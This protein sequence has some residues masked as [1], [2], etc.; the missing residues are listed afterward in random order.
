[1]PDQ[2]V[3]LQSVKAPTRKF[4]VISFDKETGLMKLRT[5]SGVLFEY[6]NMTKEKAKQFG[7][8]LVTE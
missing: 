6:E 4:E 8:Q 3:Y 2:K 5:P 1:M 7:Y